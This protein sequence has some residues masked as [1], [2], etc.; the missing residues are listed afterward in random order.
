MAPPRTPEAGQDTNID[1]PSIK[2]RIASINSDLS[3]KQVSEIMKDLL[4]RPIDMRYPDGN[5]DNNWTVMGVMYVAGNGDNDP[6]GWKLRVKGN[7]PV[8]DHKGNVIYPQGTIW[9]EQLAEMQSGPE[10]SAEQEERPQVRKLLDSLKSDLQPEQAQ[11]ILS[12]LQDQE[13]TVPRRS[14]TIEDGWKIRNIYYRDGQDNE[15]GQWWVNVLSDEIVP[16]KDGPRRLTKDLRASELAMYQGSDEEDTPSEEADEPIAEDPELLQA[17]ATDR[18]LLSKSAAFNI[19]LREIGKGAMNALDTGLNR[20]QNHSSPRLAHR[21]KAYNKAKVG[22]LNKQARADQAKNRMSKAIHERRAQKAQSKLAVKRA[23][24]R[25]SL[26]PKNART[27]Q[28][29]ER[30]AERQSVIDNRIKAY[31]DIGSEKAARKAANAQ[32]KTEHTKYGERKQAIQELMQDP[33]M[34]ETIRRAG[35]VLIEHTKTAKEAKTINRTQERIDNRG[36][37]LASSQEQIENRITSLKKAAAETDGDITR[38]EQTDIPDAGK[39]LARWAQLH[40]HATVNDDIAAINK[41]LAHAQEHLNQLRLDLQRRQKHRKRLDA[42]I[43]RAE[44]RQSTV[45]TKLQQNEEI[46]I[47]HSLDIAE[48]NKAHV[49]TSQQRRSRAVDEIVGTHTNATNGGTV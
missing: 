42:L 13:V 45:A 31:V 18:E 28:R 4:G 16:T 44:G 38:L 34:K 25:E 14:G 10:P 41:G 3:P 17:Q 15:P 39:E 20:L 46:S 48:P 43:E 7:N 9:P 32:L 1:E 11:L 40:M 19:K 35:R 29:K 21:L 12:L 30:M 27:V 26:E 49:Q 2:E 6:G 8:T 47:N 23:N 5:I 36:H 33:A 37:K 22:Y 24:L